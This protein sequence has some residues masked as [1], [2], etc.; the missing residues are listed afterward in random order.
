M[1]QRPKS[2]GYL[3]LAGKPSVIRTEFCLVRKAIMSSYCWYVYAWMHSLFFFNSS[4]KDN[5]CK[6]YS[7]KKKNKWFGHLNFPSKYNIISW[8][9]GAFS[10][11]QPHVCSDEPIETWNCRQQS[12]ERDNMGVCTER[13]CPG[14]GICHRL[15]WSKQR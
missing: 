15:S 4:K 13:N 8:Y 9:F 10:R 1:G 6:H 5:K 12:S 3:L 7:F 14:Q 2:M 11:I